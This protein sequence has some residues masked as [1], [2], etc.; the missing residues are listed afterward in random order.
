M[1]KIGNRVKDTASNFKN[2]LA[3]SR[4]LNP[5]NQAKELAATAKTMA[6]AATPW[7]AMALAKKVDFSKDVFFVPAFVAAVLKDVLDFALIGSL[8]AIGTVITVCISIFIW[9]MMLLAGASSKGKIV[10]GMMKRSMVLI[11]GTMTEFLFGLN[12]LPLETITVAIIYL[13]VLSER[14][15]G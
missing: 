3:V 2:S 8:P 15:K 10:R 11:G 7:G 5:G 4:K 14:K 13:M 1:S 12:F 6:A 9:F